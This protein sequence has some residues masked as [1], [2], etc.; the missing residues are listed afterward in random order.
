MFCNRSVGLPPRRRSPAPRSKQDTKDTAAV[1]VD[2]SSESGL[3]ILYIPPRTEV[4]SQKAVKKNE[5][6]S[7]T[8]P[9]EDSVEEI[10]H[11]S[12]D[13]IL[14][15]GRNLLEVARDLLQVVHQQR[16][17]RQVYPAANVDASTESLKRPLPNTG[18]D[19]PDMSGRCR[20][21]HLALQFDNAEPDRGA[22][23]NMSLNT[24]TTTRKK[25]AKCD[26]YDNVNNRSSNNMDAKH[27]QNS[28]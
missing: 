11:P 23:N 8:P 2:S 18:T 10:P 3:K 28:F 27:P 19:S 26:D 9:S 6:D 13:E 12:N 22:D 17:Q 15:M 25:D 4:D 20:S 21:I 24:S 7:N 16:S 5:R 1:A 14:E